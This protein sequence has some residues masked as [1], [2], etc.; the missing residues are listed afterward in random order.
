MTTV[1]LTY[2]EGSEYFRAHHSSQTNPSVVKYGIGPT[3]EIW[4]HEV[5]NDLEAKSLKNH[6][7]K[8]GKRT[9]PGSLNFWA[10]LSDLSKENVLKSWE[11]PSADIEKTYSILYYYPEEDFYRVTYSKDREVV[12][13]SQK[14]IWHGVTNDREMA[15][16]FSKFINSNW[17]ERYTVPKGKFGEFTKGFKSDNLDRVAMKQIFD[18]NKKAKTEVV[19]L[20]PD[21]PF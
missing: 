16:E 9:G 14:C 20:T 3:K 19:D 13:D 21:I 17:G 5:S 6:I 15:I 10:S 12:T 8:F 4:S 18:A 11:R 1:Y 7:V 2:F